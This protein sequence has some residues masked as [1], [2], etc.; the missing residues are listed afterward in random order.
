MLEREQRLLNW[1][2]AHMKGYVGPVKVE[3]R[4]RPQ[5][6]SGSKPVNKD[7]SSGA[8]QTAGICD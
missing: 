5:Q 1:Q 6:P 7:K 2:N 3:H 4:S 8:D